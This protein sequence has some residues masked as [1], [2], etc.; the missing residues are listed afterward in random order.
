MDEKKLR[1]FFGNFKEKNFGRKKKELL[2]IMQAVPIF[3]IYC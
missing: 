1:L 3:G 2:A